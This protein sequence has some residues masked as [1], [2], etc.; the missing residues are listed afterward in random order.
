VEFV[1]AWEQMGNATEDVER[2]SS[3]QSRS[4]QGADAAYYEVE[5][6]EKT[7]QVESMPAASESGDLVDSPGSDELS[8]A[9]DSDD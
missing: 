2:D 5:G 4:E 6:L 1:C 9:L 3:D 7:D 8:G